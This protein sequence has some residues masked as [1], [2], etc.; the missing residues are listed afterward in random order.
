MSNVPHWRELGTCLAAERRRAWLSQ[1]D[2]AERVGISQA[3][4]SLIERGLVRPRPANLLHLAVV[5]SV[6]ID[7]LA[8]IARY[9]LEHVLPAATVMR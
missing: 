6:E 7:R 9:P 1:C 8:L 5:L 4:Y 3:A 2:V